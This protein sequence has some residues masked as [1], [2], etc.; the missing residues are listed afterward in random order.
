MHIGPF[1]FHFMKTSHPVPCFAMRIEVGGTSLVYTGDSTYMEEFID[2]AKNADILLCESNF[3][4]D[5]DGSN[6]GHMTAREAGAYRSEGKRTTFDI[7]PPTTLRRSST[8][9]EEA[10]EVFTRGIA[11]RKAVWNFNFNRK[12]KKQ[13]RRNHHAFY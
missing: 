1:T 7:D 4:S 3:Y 9:V 6:A 2:F 8:V 12:R 13:R 11:L 10:G 5:M